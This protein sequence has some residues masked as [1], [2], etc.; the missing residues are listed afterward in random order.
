MIFEIDKQ[1]FEKRK[2][3]ISEEKG[4]NPLRYYENENKYCLY[5]TDIDNQT[6]KTTIY[7][8][9]FADRISE[10]NFK[11]E[12]INNKTRIITELAINEENI[13]YEELLQ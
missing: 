4:R 2:N 12:N 3:V 11:N 10:T 5:L 8:S 1:E 6:I 13:N 9:E 7:K